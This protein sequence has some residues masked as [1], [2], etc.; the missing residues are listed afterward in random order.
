MSLRFD[1][2]RAMFPI[3]LFMGAWGVGSWLLYGFNITTIYPGTY[4][5]TIMIGGF[6]FL[7]ALGFLMTAIPAF[8]ETQSAN[9]A[10]LGFAILLS[11]M[12]ALA[13]V[14]DRPILFHRILF[15]QMV[16]LIIFGARRILKR[17]D[18]PP[19]SFVFVGLGILFGVFGVGIICLDD[20]G[21]MSGSWRLL[22]HGLF[23]QGMMLSLVLGVGSRL[24]PALTG[25]E[26]PP[27]VQIAPSIQ[28]NLESKFLSAQILLLLGLAGFLT[29]SF[30]LEAFVNI[31][32]GRILRAIVTT[33]I[34]IRF[35]KIYKFPLEK[36][37]LSRW[38]WTSG[39]CVSIGLWGYALFPSYGI[40]LLHITF[41][42]GFSL[43]TLMIATRVTL[44]HG[45]HGYGLEGSS[46]V[47][48]WAGILILSA[49]VTRVL[50]PFTMNAYRTHLGYASLAWI[51][52]IIFWSWVF[53]KKIFILSESVHE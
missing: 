14:A 28:I 2:Y 38:L 12:L 24:I 40:H 51:V 41:V 1:P 33:I 27:L 20:V 47:L 4:H 22:G 15:A 16:A 3:G 37:W 46:K 9:S 42:G 19:P 29:T 36:T 21:F 34:A 49:M 17:N 44:A 13:G 35:W 10:E 53:V 23:F 25:W 5:A 32:V 31:Q 50:A 26:D 30:F 7:F 48:K 8:T 6:L 39:W 43:M 52:A 11:A 45:G 18:N